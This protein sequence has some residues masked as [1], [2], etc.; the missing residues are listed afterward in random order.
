MAPELIGAFI[1]LLVPCCFGAGTVLARVGLV[2]IPA[3]TGNF[4]SLVSG[5]AVLA[6]VAGVFF[7]PELAVSLAVVGWLAMLGFIN[8]PVGRFLNFVSLSKLGVVRANPVLALSPVVSAFEGVVFLD[9][10]VNPAIVAGTLAAVAGVIVTVGGEARARGAPPTPIREG[11]VGTRRTQIAG[12]LAAAG[13][14]CAYGTVP[15]VGRVAVTEL[16]APIVTAAITMAF[17]ALFMG[18]MVAR[19]APRDLRNAPRR[20]VLLVCAGGVFMSTGVA[21]LYLALS[22]APV[23]VVSPVFALTPV[24]GMALAHFFLQRLERVTRELALGTALVVAG[25]IAVMVGTQL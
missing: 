18:M 2:H 12:Y 24:V 13:A 14:A 17:G 1:A 10:R 23:I 6:V 9:E 16:A 21:M 3:N 20:S 19:Q 8:F 22:K 25:V 7:R 11:A 4:I 5:G 15:A